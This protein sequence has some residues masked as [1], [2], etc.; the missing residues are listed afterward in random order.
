MESCPT[1]W[2]HVTCDSVTQRPTGIDLSELPLG[3]D[4]A[5]GG[6]QFL[7]DM[8]SGTGL[9]ALHVL[10]LSH[11]SLA[12]NMN[13]MD[14]SGLLMLKVLDLRFMPNLE[15]ALNPLWAE[16]MPGIEE[17]YLAVAPSVVSSNRHN[18]LSTK[19]V[20][21]RQTRLLALPRASHLQVIRSGCW[22]SVSCS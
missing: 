17:F 21:A 1:V 6:C 12:L 11:T 8:F 3:C 20:G 14:L 10:K 16:W 19:P 9:T 13:L 4:Q 18:T 2:E 15:G 7:P 22:C 5:V